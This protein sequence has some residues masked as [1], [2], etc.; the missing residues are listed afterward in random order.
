MNFPST[1][2]MSDHNT[3]KFEK[4]DLEFRPILKFLRQTKT[5]LTYAKNS[6]TDTRALLEYNISQCKIT[7]P[8]DP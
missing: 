3:Q 1:K 8:L 4:S 7:L 5:T 2:S 6:N